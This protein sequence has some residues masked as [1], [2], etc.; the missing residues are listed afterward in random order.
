MSYEL[1][2]MSGGDESYKWP[3]S[4]ANLTATIPT[5]SHGP[6]NCYRRLQSRRK[7]IEC[8]YHELEQNE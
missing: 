6:G 7:S 8:W 2:A 4:D 3:R 5:S 1:W